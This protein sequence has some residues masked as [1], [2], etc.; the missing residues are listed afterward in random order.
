MT[1][2]PEQVTHPLFPRFRLRERLGTGAHGVAY[3]ALDEE[4]GAAVILHDLVNLPADAARVGRMRARVA[5]T[6]LAAHPV[7]TAPIAFDLDQSRPFIVVD[8]HRRLHTLVDRARLSATRRAQLLL[9]LAGALAAA[10]R[11]GLVHGSLVPSRVRLVDDEPR[12]D[13]LAIRTGAAP[14]THALDSGCGA[15]EEEPSP[16]SDVLAFGRLLRFLL[17]SDDD[18]STLLKEMA[19]LSGVIAR[20]TE[21]DPLARPDMVEV[22]ALLSDALE[23]EATL[24]GARRKPAKANR[25]DAQVAGTSLARGDKRTIGRFETI[26]LIGEGAA[27]RVFRARDLSTGDFVALKVLAAGANA[28]PRV[29]LR[30]QKEARLLSEIESP[31]LIRFIDAGDDDGELFLAMEI[32][33]GEDANTLLLREGQLS[34]ERAVHII[35]DAARGAAA[36]HARGIVHRDIKPAN[37]VLNAPTG[38]EAARGRVV[39]RLVDFGIARHVDESASLAMTADGALIGTPFYMAP[40][41][42]SGDRVTPATDVYALAA[43]LFHLMAGRPVFEG[44]GVATV[45][46]QHLNETPVRL[47]SV[48][49]D[50]PLALGALVERALSKAPDERPRDGAVFVD[51]LLAA[52]GRAPESVTKHPAPIASSLRT[53]RFVMSFDLR[54]SPTALWPLV[55]DTDRVNRAAGLAAVAIHHRVVGDD[56]EQHAQMRALGI[57]VAWREY[58]FEWIENRR[59]G[60][61]REY[62]S[63]PFHWLRSVVELTPTDDGGTRLVQVFEIVPRGLL[64]AAAAALEVNMRVRRALERVYRRIDRLLVD[65]GGRDAY[66]E[67]LPLTSDAALR[68]ARIEEALARRGHSPHGI[69]ALGDLLRNANAKDLARIR[70]VTFAERAGLT[71]DAALGLLFSAVVEGALELRWDILCPMCRIASDMVDTLRALEEHG[72][73]D[74]CQLDYELDLAR[75]VELVL[76]AHPAIREPER[77]VFCASSPGHSPHV[78]ARLRVADGETLRVPLALGAGSY[79]LVGRHLPFR[80]DF[81]VEQRAVTASAEVDLGAALHARMPMRFA[82]REQVLTLVNTSGREQLVRIESRTPRADVFTAADASASALFRAFFPGEV[83]DG[84]RLF[85]TSRAVVGV[86]D[87]DDAAHFFA[88]EREREASALFASLYAALAAHASHHGGAVVRVRDPGVLVAF[89]DPMRAIAWALDLQRPLDEIGALSGIVL[90]AGLHIGSARIVTLNGRLDYFGGL[91]F[92]AAAL[93][94]RAPLGTCLVSEE[95]SRDAAVAREFSSPDRTLLMVRSP[96]GG[97]GVALPIA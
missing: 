78:K 53:R 97:V 67:P 8:D 58:P 68:L 37:I 36:A 83:L 11:V 17:S 44:P 60:V 26:E 28:S 50:V 54:S 2:S 30:F 74:A 77:A 14:R 51:E 92:D 29:L 84:A 19:A 75:S 43:T 96:V 85:S 20:A 25:S 7:L 47:D 9:S 95:L 48:V 65:S 3:A 66:V 90:R 5:R 42:A 6:R 41:Q 71:R 45:I 69:A 55:S 31:Y 12:L 93:A 81:V 13:L 59:F 39:A 57:D 73:C 34:I 4:T 49:R 24:D 16:I 72:R 21:A 52:I 79:S 40:E 89:T 76:S 22:Q 32:V 33:E 27:G 15:P 46:A 91:V 86:V 64:G 1:T 82:T 18:S 62:E 70:P 80:Y 10:H 35:A 94:A 61:L 87:V 38:T 88:P 56:V 23:G 63:G